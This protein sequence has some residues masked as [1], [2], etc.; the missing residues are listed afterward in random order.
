MNDGERQKNLKIKGVFGL[1]NSFVEVCL[2]NKAPGTNGV[3]VLESAN[4]LTN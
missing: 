4:F 2:P 3:G 1:F